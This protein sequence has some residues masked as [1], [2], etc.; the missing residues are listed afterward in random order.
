MSYT[1]LLVTSLFI[2]PWLLLFIHRKDLRKEMFATSIVV[3]IIGM[4]AEA[5][6]YTVDWWHPQTITNTKIG[7][8]DFLLGFT[9]GGI[10]SVLYK[11]VLHKT[12]Y[13]TVK[14]R[15]SHWVLVLPL[16]LAAAIAHI[17][18]AYF[19]WFSFWANV[20]GISIG[21]ILMSLLRRDLE[22]EAIT[23]GLLLTLLT[24]P[25]YW[26]G[27]FFFPTVYKDFWNFKNVSGFYLLGIPYE[28]LIWWFFV[29]ALMSI[30]Y[31]YWHLV[32]LRKL[33]R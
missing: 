11:E 8:E 9:T 12:I 25:L 10:A 28:D 27:T 21:L 18:F 1:Y 17:L 31:D 20:A 4:V 13:K 7:I 32:K 22:K 19:D 6:W 5:I 16:F 15:I 29:G 2:I 14:L 30:L 3:A 33:R 24:I 26:I 23:G